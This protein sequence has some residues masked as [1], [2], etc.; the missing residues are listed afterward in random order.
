M[1]VTGFP[2]IFHICPTSFPMIFHIAC[3]VL[4]I[5]LIFHFLFGSI[6]EMLECAL[7]YCFIFKEFVAFYALF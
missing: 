6:Q 4:I 1:A 2:F 5:G 3:W 7:V